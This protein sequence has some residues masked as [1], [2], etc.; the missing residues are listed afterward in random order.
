MK[1]VAGF[2]CGTNSIRLIVA[3]IDYA[4]PAPRLIDRVR[5][6]RIV[7]LG[8]GVDRT[9]HLDPAAMKRT[10]DAVHEFQGITKRW[11]V[12]Q[13]RFVATSATRDAD[14]SAEFAAGIRD[15]LGVEPEVIA[16][17]EEASLSF[18]G[19]ASHVGTDEARPILV[20]DIGG[21][22]TELVLGDQ[23]VCQAVS[24]NMGSVR[25]TE[26]FVH[27]DLQG[28]IT[29]QERQRACAW[30]DQQ[31]DQAENA[32]DLTRVRTL[33]GVAGTVTTVTAQALGLN[34][35]EPERIDGAVLS[36]DQTR[37]AIDFLVNQPVSRKAQLGFMPKGRADVIGAGALVWERI[38]TRVSQRSQA[39]GFPINTSVTSEHDILDGIAL[40]LS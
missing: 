14:N 10:L 19:A 36:F 15:I 11:G 2:D 25:V 22:S 26:K 38:I 37:E 28:C 33:V 32:V 18:R 20:V 4:G 24:V 40:S 13:M 30:I 17:V 31:L 3:D 29:P 16:G 1:R 12:E 23:D 39:A 35:Y 21:G 6:M 5:E 9:G 27:E 8:Q 7:R 34:R